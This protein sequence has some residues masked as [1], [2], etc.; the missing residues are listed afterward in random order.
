MI[1]NK[2]ES[3][4]DL[5]MLLCGGDVTAYKQLQSGTVEDYLTK[6]ANFVKELEAKK[7]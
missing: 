2:E 1:L 7:K 6:M 4:R 3:D 5:L